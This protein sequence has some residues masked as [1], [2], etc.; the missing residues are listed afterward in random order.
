MKVFGFIAVVVTGIMLLYA[1]GD[2]P[3]WGNSESPASKSPVSRHYITRGMAETAVP[4]MVTAVLGDYRSYD[5]LFET[6]VVFTAGIAIIGILGVARLTDRESIDPQPETQLAD[7]DR[8]VIYTCRLLIPVMQL[9]ALYVVAHGHHSPGGGFQGG[10][11][12]GASFIL[13]AIARDLPTALRRVPPRRMI[14]LAGTGV[15]IY[16]GIGALCA[17]MGG[18]FLDFSTLHSL[19][20]GTD[21]VMARSH[22]ILGIEIGVAFTVSAIMFGIYTY[23]SS[24][25]RLKGGL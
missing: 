25:G 20:P 6:V 18:R 16:A 2:F 5:T 7:R 11:I 13:W 22:G 3:A 15:L 1:A 8:I 17:L 19:L 4:N 9:F 12:L 23:L 14:L 21:A 24:N 10:V